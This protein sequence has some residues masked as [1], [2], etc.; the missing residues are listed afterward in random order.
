[1]GF[2]NW[3]GGACGIHRTAQPGLAAAGQLDEPHPVQR[4]RVAYVAA[5]HIVTPELLLK[6][7]SVCGEADF[8][9]VQPQLLRPVAACEFPVPPRVLSGPCSHEVKC[10]AAEVLVGVPQQAADGE[11]EQGLA[12]LPRR[13]GWR[14]VLRRSVVRPADLVLDEVGR[15]PT[16]KR[17]GS[18]GA[19]D[20]V[21]ALATG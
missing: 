7:P 14:L 19:A 16:Q 8:G 11:E 10:R 13:G 12:N 9:Y 17:L 21:A 2:Q 20:R 15:L 18:A 5:A 1:M 4:V 3:L 6:L